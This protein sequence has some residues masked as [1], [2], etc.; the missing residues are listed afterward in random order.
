MA[1][2]YVTIGTVVTRDIFNGIDARSEAVTTSA[3]AAN[4]GIIARVGQAAQVLCATH[5]YA[6]SGTGITLTNGIYCPANV[7]TF[8]AMTEGQA[9][10]IIDAV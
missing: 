7:P 4:G 10:S 5:V 9:I 8:I 6:K 3:A 2:A 1:T